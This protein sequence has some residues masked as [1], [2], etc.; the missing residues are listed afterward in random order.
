MN[1]K[2][3]L[4]QSTGVEQSITLTDAVITANRIALDW[5][6][7]GQQGHLIA[8]STNGI[9]FSGR[10]GYGR[11][12]PGFECELTLYKSNHEDLLY[13]TWRQLD[14]G[15]VGTLILRLPGRAI[16]T[17]SADTAPPSEDSPPGEA[18]SPAEI[19]DAPETR[20]NG[21]AAGEGK[22]APLRLAPGTSGK[23]PS[24]RPTKAQPTKAQSNVAWTNRSPEGRPAPKESTAGA[25]A[26]PSAAGSAPQPPVALA[27][28][29]Q[30]PASGQI[31]HLLLITSEQFAACDR[32]AMEKEL[33]AA[34]VSALF[35]VAHNALA[36]EVRGMAAS[37]FA[38]R[39]GDL[40]ENP[41]PKPPTRPAETPEM[42]AR[43][44]RSSRH[45]T[46]R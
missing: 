41:G 16:E 22:V 14:T 33:L 12:S 35:K 38:Q 34:P 18:D 3:R 24:P 8:K 36:A 1:L 10:Y 20:R 5:D 25:E 4:V 40:P 11:K 39:Y 26:I 13:G 7:N 19:A 44:R 21:P 15:Q 30:P 27:P 17:R 29:A 43:K 28:V 32:G 37:M 46:N 31:D 9:H 2:G 23:M 45:K 6:H 42:K